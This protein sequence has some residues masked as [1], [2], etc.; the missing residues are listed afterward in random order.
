MKRIIAILLAATAIVLF[1][2]AAK[3]AQKREAVYQ[4]NLHCAKCA[5]KIQNNVAFEKGV[6]DLEISVPDKTVR[7]VYKAG[8]T[9]AETLAKAI[10]DL[11]Y[12]VELISD[13]EVK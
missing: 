7:I 9:D 6:V 10:K 12:K 13:K 3:P 1:T 11:G 4:T 5:E 2:S 8:K